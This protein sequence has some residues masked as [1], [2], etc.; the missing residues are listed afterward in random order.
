MDKNYCNH[1]NITQS[2]IS[3]TTTIKTNVYIM[4]I[5]KEITTYIYT[6]ILK[7]ERRALGTKWQQ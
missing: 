2:S 7:D 1:Y 6:A 3:F 4:T 5:Y